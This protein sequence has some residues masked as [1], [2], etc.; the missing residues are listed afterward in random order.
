[1]KLA[2]TF[3]HFHLFI[4]ILFSSLGWCVQF[5]SSPLWDLHPGTSRSW[6]ARRASCHGDKRRASSSH[7]GMPATRCWYETKYARNH[8]W[9]RTTN[10]RLVLKRSAFSLFLKRKKKRKN[11]QTKMACVNWLF[12]WLSANML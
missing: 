1:M 11:L 7:S 4:V 9:T 3:M 8:W 10:I 12:S 6:Q 2:G 5:W